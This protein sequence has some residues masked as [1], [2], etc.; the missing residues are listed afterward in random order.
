MIRFVSRKNQ[1]KQTHSLKAISKSGMHN[2]V[3]NAN[4]PS[5]NHRIKELALVV[6]IWPNMVRDLQKII[7]WTEVQNNYYEIF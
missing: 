5:E 6:C 3:W 1:Y 4:Y 7:G 2:P